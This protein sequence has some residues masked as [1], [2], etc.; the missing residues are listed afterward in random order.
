M[1]NNILD[2]EEGEGLSLERASNL[3]SAWTCI[4]FRRRDKWYNKAAADDN[5]RESV[6]RN[7]VG[8]VKKDSQQLSNNGSARLLTMKLQDCE[9]LLT[10]YSCIATGDWQGLTGCSFYLKLPELTPLQAGCLTDWL[11]PATNRGSKSKLDKEGWQRVQVVSNPTISDWRNLIFSLRLSGLHLVFVTVLIV[12]IIIKDSLD[13]I[14]PASWSLSFY[15]NI[16][17]RLF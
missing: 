1:W 15:W 4:D 17:L 12:N 10:F 16:N 3:C 14:T 13:P 5:Y 9:G 2:L 11:Q 6:F 8:P 7:T